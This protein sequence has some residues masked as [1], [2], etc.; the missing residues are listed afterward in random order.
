MTRKF[1]H[2][3]KKRQTDECVMNEAPKWYAEK[4][5]TQAEVRE[6]V[7]ACGAVDAI[8]VDVPEFHAILRAFGRPIGRIRSLAVNGVPIK[9]MEILEQS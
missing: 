2:A 5:R 3:S 9:A 6:F 1:A 7:K 4:K 8:W